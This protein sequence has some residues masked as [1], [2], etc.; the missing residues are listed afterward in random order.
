MNRLRQWFRQ[1]RRAFQGWLF[2]KAV[3]YGFEYLKDQHLGQRLNTAMDA[4]FGVER[5]NT[6]QKELATWLRAMATEVEV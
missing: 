4:K 5:S 1:R 3:V 6:V 2:T